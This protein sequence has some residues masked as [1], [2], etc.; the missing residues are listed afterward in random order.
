VLWGDDVSF[1][2]DAFNRELSGAMRD[3]ASQ[4]LDD[5][6][7]NLQALLDDM[8]RT[9]GGMPEAEVQDELRRRAA[10]EGFHLSDEHVAAYAG[11]IA[12]GRHINVVV[13]KSALDEL[14]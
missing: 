4:G 3:V 1:D 8:E 14:R 7:A 9:H 10:G 2:A 11:A 6:G 13:D 5:I 12:E